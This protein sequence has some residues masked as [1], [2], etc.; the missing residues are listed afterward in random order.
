[1]LTRKVFRL[2]GLASGPLRRSGQRTVLQDAKPGRYPVDS[3]PGTLH[4]ESTAVMTMTIIF[5]KVGLHDDR[6]TH[7]CVA[8]GGAVL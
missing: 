7:R 6:R 1:M 8:V 3:F 5:T 2:K 4:M